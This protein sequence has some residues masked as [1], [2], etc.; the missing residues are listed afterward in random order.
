MVRLT[1]WLLVLLLSV[2]V[3]TAAE[4]T[5]AR[6]F[7]S[8]VRQA[9]A[10]VASRKTPR[11]LVVARGVA[12]TEVG[13]ASLAGVARQARHAIFHQLQEKDLVP[14][15]TAAADSLVKEL[16][17]AVLLADRD[18]TR[19]R[20]L[21]GA[22]TVL[23]IDVFERRGRRYLKLV[24]DEGTET[25]KDWQRQVRLPDASQNRRSAGRPANGSAVPS[26]ACPPGGG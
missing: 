21:T 13:R 18:V 19:L 6:R 9:T 7:R 20:E 11:V 14:V 22:Q 2:S 23:V 26:V 25:A 10:T 12:K 8:L 4:T 24:V 3:A 17:S 1:G 5:A 16:P 15:V